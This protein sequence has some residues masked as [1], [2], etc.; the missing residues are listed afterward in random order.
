[1]SSV[2]SPARQLDAGFVRSRMGSL[3]AALPLGLWTV[4][5]LWNNLSAFKGAAAWQADV[6]EYAHPAAF[7]VSSVV[8]LLPLAL[9][10]IWG[11]ARLTMVRPNNL[12]YRSFDNLK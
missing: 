8:A 6:T 10:T 9:H 11:I 5:H 3:L 7:F 12:R 2:A 4:N 1:M